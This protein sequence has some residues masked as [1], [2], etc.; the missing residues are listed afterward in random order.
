MKFDKSEIDFDAQ[1]LDNLRLSQKFNGP[2]EIKKLYNDSIS[3]PVN[4]KKANSN[5]NLIQSGLDI[6]NSSSSYYN[7][8]PSILKKSNGNKKHL[9]KIIAY[10]DGNTDFS[11][12]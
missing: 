5:N 10:E 11:K 3:K 12:Y 8:N 6:N 9:K 7:F 1:K 2:T 4:Y